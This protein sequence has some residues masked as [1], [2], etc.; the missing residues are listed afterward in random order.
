MNPVRSNNPNLKYQRFTPSGCKVTGIRKFKFVA[1]TQFLYIVFSL[2]F[3]M[4]CKINSL[5]PDWTLYLVLRGLY[6]M[7]TR[8]T[9]AMRRTRRRRGTRRTRRMRVGWRAGRTRWPTCVHLNSKTRLSYL[10]RIVF[11]K[12]ILLQFARVINDTLY[13]YLKTFFWTP[14]PFSFFLSS[15]L[16]LYK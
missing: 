7:S 10:S 5:I 9:R 15:T 12:F 4:W 14:P 1:K 3:E 2:D 13:V 8:R 11:L 16:I 6:F